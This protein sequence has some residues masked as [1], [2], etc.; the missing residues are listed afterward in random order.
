MASKK[1]KDVS[2]G[3][4]I[5]DKD[6]KRTEILSASREDKLKNLSGAIS[7]IEK[8]FGKGSVQKLGDKVGVE[9]PHI[10][11]GIVS[12]DRATGIGG[13]PRGRIIEVFGPE[14]AGKTSF[15]L[16][17]VSKVQKAGGLAALIDVEHALDPAFAQKLGVNVDDLIVAQPD[18]GEEALEIAESL[19]RSNSL[20]VLI[21]DSTAALVP[22]AEIEGSMGDAVM[23]GQARLLSQAMR[24]LTGPISRS[25]A[26]VIFISQIRMKIGCVAP[27]TKIQ[28]VK[29]DRA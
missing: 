22:K 23:G 3:Q 19:I 21:V 24:K 20:D 1:D 7:Q 14:S 29:E 4:I 2:M 28:W 15:C 18:S 13:L 5:N 11:T 9:Y 27:S 26:V 10:E 16:N 8:Q 17:L 25:G 12:F 6:A